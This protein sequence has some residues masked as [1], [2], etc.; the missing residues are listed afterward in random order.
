MV[1]Q[2]QSLHALHHGV[3]VGVCQLKALDVFLGDCC[4]LIGL[5]GPLLSGEGWGLISHARGDWWGHPPKCWGPL[6]Y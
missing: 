3:D 1:L 4:G 6:S 5:L 2:D